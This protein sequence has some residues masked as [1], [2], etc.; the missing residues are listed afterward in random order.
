MARSVWS[1]SGLPCTLYSLP[2]R[3]IERENPKGIPAQS[4]DMR[5]CEL[6]WDRR[7]GENNPEGG[8][9]HTERPPTNKP[10]PRWGCG[11]ISM[12]SQ[13]SSRTRNPYMFSFMISWLPF[14]VR[15]FLGCTAPS[16]GCLRRCSTEASV[17]SRS[18]AA[19]QA[20]AEPMTGPHSRSPSHLCFH[21]FSAVLSLFCFSCLGKKMRPVPLRKGRSAACASSCNP[22]TALGQSVAQPEPRTPCGLNS[23]CCQSGGDCRQLVYVRMS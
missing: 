8:C 23:N 6:P 5:A 2:Q 4:P 15:L 9:G 13:G 10:Q 21:L 12:L 19:P 17:A 11:D 1:A 14:W 16:E 20:V 7:G 3:E 18:G 22:R